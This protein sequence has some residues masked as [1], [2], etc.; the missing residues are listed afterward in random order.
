MA[1]RALILGLT[2]LGV[3]SGVMA[4]GVLVYKK[5]KI[6]QSARFT[7]EAEGMVR[8][9]RIPEACMSLD[10]ALRLNPGN[11]DALRQLALLQYAIGEKGNALLS[12]QKL[13]DAGEL[14][15]RDAQAFA[16]LAA[17]HQE[18]ELADRIVDSLRAGNT[19]VLPYLLEA[20]I[21]TM[22]GDIPQ[23][24]AALRKAIQL[25]GTSRSRAA[26][27]GFLLANR[28]DAENAPEIFTLLSE[29]AILQNELG[30]AALV[31]GLAKNL[32][33]VELLPA[34]IES[35]R[36]HPKRTEEMLLVAD[37]VEARIKPDAIPI[38]A[39]DIV[40]RLRGAA[41]QDRKKGVFWLL[42]YSHPRLAADLVTEQEALAD[43]DLFGIWLDALAASGMFDAIEQAL[44]NPSNPLRNW[45]TMLA[46][47]RILKLQG[48]IQEGQLA[49][50]SALA[51][52]GE[53]PAEQVKVVAYLFNDL[54]TDL[55]VQ[56]LRTLLADPESAPQSLKLLKPIILRRGDMWELLRFHEI[57]SAA[58][59]VPF[60]L[61]IQNE[62]NYCRLILG[63]EVD[64]SSI[65]LL[66]KKNPDNL[67]FRITNALVLLRANQVA[68]AVAE[69]IVTGQPSEDPELR[70][71][72]AIASAISI[73]SAGNPEEAKAILAKI[74]NSLLTRHEV[75]L[76]QKALGGL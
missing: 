28:L 72:H 67:R 11:T 12:Y 13:A 38:L 1:H 58:D 23:A 33:P 62:I 34:W 53:N 68:K 70:A 57:T 76:V 17:L 36:A 69:L 41:V 37:T 52:T 39:E 4:G 73:A 71:R 50:E 56:G 16:L 25:D 22:R 65:A 66:A 59:G 51:A 43:A 44:G 30:A 75:A 3:V 64:A 19:D 40:S 29:L 20:D 45:Q 48:R 74:P 27:A 47:G 31:S 2:I 5:W 55:Y 26:L 42:N 46:K 6:S 54:E 63:E 15:V 14:S 49:Y 32:I 18:W 9:G 10:T 61:E 8:A 60:Q 7:A 24:E 35:M 21:S